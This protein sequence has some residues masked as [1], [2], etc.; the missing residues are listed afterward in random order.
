MRALEE[1][2]D[3]YRRVSSLSHSELGKSNRLPASVESTR[4]NPTI[5]HGP[6]ADIDW[7]V[8]SYPVC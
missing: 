2:L 3:P 1:D 5:G 8:S 6:V 7:A 4:S